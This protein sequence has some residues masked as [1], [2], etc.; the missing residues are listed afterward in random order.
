V[1]NGEEIR[2]TPTVQKQTKTAQFS[3]SY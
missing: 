2:A 1:Y 3:H